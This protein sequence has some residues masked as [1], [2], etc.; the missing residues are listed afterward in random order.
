MYIHE[1]HKGKPRPVLWAGVITDRFKCVSLLYVTRV[2]G[3]F[4]D[5][6]LRPSRPCRQAGLDEIIDLSKNFETCVSLLSWCHTCLTFSQVKQRKITTTT[7]CWAALLV[8][9][10]PNIQGHISSGP[11]EEVLLVQPCLVVHSFSQESKATHAELIEFDA[12]QQ[13]G[14]QCIKISLTFNNYRNKVLHK[15]RCANN[16][17]QKCCI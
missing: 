6:I 9:M 2:C 7:F 12:L 11:S 10:H 15:C 13:T 14:Q 1:T 5:L 16:E 17:M 4:C 3:T 8:V